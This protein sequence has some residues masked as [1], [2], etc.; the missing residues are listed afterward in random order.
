MAGGQQPAQNI[1]FY[2]NKCEWSTAFRKE[3]EKNPLIKSMLMMVS[4]D[5]DPVTG[6][7]PTFP[8]WLKKVPTL[9]IK[10]DDDPVK[11]DSEVFNWL[12]AMKFK[13]QAATPKGAAAPDL[14]PWVSTELGGGFKDTYG[15][16]DEQE[17][18]DFLTNSHTFQNVGGQLP[19][20]GVR[21]SSDMTPSAGRGGEGK[22]TKADLFDKQMQE[23]MKNRGAGVP[24]ARPRQ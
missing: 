18:A 4:V 6:K 16:I 9:Y 12:D 14:T 8:P 20:P 19:A 23:Y 5:P 22:S 11:I 2:S 24:Q 3:L 13:I 21:T 1:C 10:G 7:R 15:F 17:Q